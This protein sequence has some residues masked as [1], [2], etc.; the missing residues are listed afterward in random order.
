MESEDMFSRSDQSV[1]QGKRHEIK[2]RLVTNHQNLMFMLSAGMIIPPSGFGKKYYQDTLS[3]VPG[4][5]PL[6]PGTLW[7]SVID[8][9]I[10]EQAF[11]RPCY[12]DLDVSGVTGRIKVLRSGRWINAHFPDEVYGNEDLILVPA[13]LPVSMIKEIVFSSKEDKMFCEKDA[14]NFSNVPLADFKTKTAATAFKKSKK[15]A[16]LPPIDGVEERQ[17]ELK[18]PDALGGVVAVL[19]QL[20]NRDDAAIE[21]HKAFYQKT[22]DEEVFSKFPLLLGAHALFYSSQ[23]EDESLRASSTLFGNI[24]G[25]LLHARDHIGLGSSKDVV[26]AVLEEVNSNTKGQN[27]VKSER[28]IQDLKRVIQFPNK[29]LEELVEIHQGPLSR[30][31]ILFFIN[32]TVLDLLEITNDQVSGYEKCAAAVLFGIAEGWMRMTVSLRESNG[33]NLVAP[34]YMAHLSHQ[35]SGSILEFGALP[36]RPQSLRALLSEN[37]SDKKVHA[38]ALLIARACKWDCIKTRIKLGKGNYQL[39]IDGSGV[40]LMLDGDV[41]AVEQELDYEKFMDLLNSESGITVKVENEAR[42]ILRGA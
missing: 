16:C 28:L 22:P 14:Q 19:N 32:D 12:A 42:K 37:P 31:L 30:A 1:M 20:A 8:H 4:W 3:L 11:L 10:S 39:F 41:K 15:D 27:K 38:A 24:A 2:W 35:L 34:A 7:Q 26:M 18:L 5:V 25:S 29:T 6:F 21:L 33:L 13:P 40:S 17:I 36:D 9:S 23:S